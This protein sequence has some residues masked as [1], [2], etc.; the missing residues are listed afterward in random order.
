MGQGQWNDSMAPINEYAAER[1]DMRN[2]LVMET[3]RLHIRTFQGLVLIMQQDKYVNG[4]VGV[5]GALYV[6]FCLHQRHRHRYESLRFSA[7]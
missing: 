5:T 2:W 3:L 1:Q 6:Y 7:R 4:R